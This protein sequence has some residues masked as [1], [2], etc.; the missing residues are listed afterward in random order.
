MLMEAKWIGYAFYC[1]PYANVFMFELIACVLQ[2]H[3]V[4]IEV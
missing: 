1:I 3:T 2:K 4:R